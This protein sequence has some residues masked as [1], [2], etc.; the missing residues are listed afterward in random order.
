MK[1]QDMKWLCSY[2][3]YN[4]ERNTIYAC[5]AYTDNDD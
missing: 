2:Y 5:I 4:A 1:K 3:I